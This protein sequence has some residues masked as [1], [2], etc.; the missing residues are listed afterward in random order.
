MVS[1]QDTI[2]TCHQVYHVTNQTCSHTGA[3]ET[4]PHVGDILRDMSVIIFGEYHTGYIA[5]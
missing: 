4:C 3:L 1:F 5:N 2:C